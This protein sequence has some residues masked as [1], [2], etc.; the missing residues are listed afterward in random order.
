MIKLKQ[1][2]VVE[3]NG[4]SVFIVDEPP[5]ANEIMRCGLVLLFTGTW[6]Q[7]RRFIDPNY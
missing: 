5:S 2:Y 1:Y 4:W 7:C 3:Y 6:E